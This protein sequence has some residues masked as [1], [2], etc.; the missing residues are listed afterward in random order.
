MRKKLSIGYGLD[1]CALT[2]TRLTG[3]EKRILDGG[4][5]MLH[6][7]RE[8]GNHYQGVG[9]LLSKQASLSLEEWEPVDERIMYARLKSIHGSMTVIVCYAPTDEADSNQKDSF[10]SKLQEVIS[11]VPKHDIL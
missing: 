8:D 6:S 5:L 7:G 10:Y 11:K 1:L 3:F 9:L 2:E 4:K